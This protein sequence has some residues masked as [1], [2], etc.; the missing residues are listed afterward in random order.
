[1][2][3]RLR[4]AATPIISL[5]A[6]HGAAI[7]GHILFTP[8]TLADSSQL[9][10]G[11]APVAVTHALQNQGAGAALISA[12]LEQCRRAGVVAVFVLGHAEYYPRFGFVPSVL[13][14]ISCEYA[15]PPENFMCLALSANLIVPDHACVRYH[16]EFARI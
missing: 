8:V 1:M 10:M 3:S 15:V 11:L 5:V 2:V 9:L 16:T 12:G 4:T 7:V 6:E 13:H 14:G